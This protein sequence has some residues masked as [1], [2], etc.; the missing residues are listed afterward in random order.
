MHPL[1]SN[2]SFSTY[3]RAARAQRGGGVGAVIATCCLVFSGASSALET[4]KEAKVEWKA[5]GNSTMAI[6]DGIRTLTME[7]NVV[8]TQGS[9]RITGDKAVFEYSVSSNEIQRITVE[10]SPVNYSQTLSND[11][12]SVTGTSTSLALYSDAAAQSIVE[13]KGNASLNSP[14]SAMSCAAI[15]Y[16]VDLDLIREATGPCSGSLDNTADN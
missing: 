2:R 11:G 12:S 3:A 4:D 16:L 10:G 8:V 6:S 14:D 5:A 15:V 1:L 9:L 13:L 7:D